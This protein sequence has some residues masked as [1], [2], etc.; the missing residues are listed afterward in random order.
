MKRSVKT[1]LRDIALV[2]LCNC[3]YAVG[4]VLFITPVS[5]ITGGTTGL[6]I[7]VHHYTQFPI[8]VFVLVFNA[9]MFLCGW[10][11]FGK[12]F[13][14]TTIVS[15]FAYPLALAFFEELFH[16][17]VLTENLML[18]ALFGGICIGVA[19]GLVIRVG[20]STGGMDIPVLMLHK[21]FRFSVSVTIYVFDVAILLLQAIFSG[22]EITLYGIVLVIVYSVVLDRVLI[23][24]QSKMQIIVI[25][26]KFEELQLRILREVDRGVTLLY[27]QTGY[28]GEETKLLLTVVSSR[29]VAKTEKIIRSIDPNA[30]MIV[31]R[32][33]EVRGRGFTSE[34][35]YLNK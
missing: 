20:S 21:F 28:L 8:S 13:A 33:S 16:G 7:F 18:C 29:E 32:V 26:R 4:V 2:F 27:G 17:V 3:L 6:A 34:K 1:L 22:A 23:V 30:F 12:K 11:T 14:L 31:N 35:N 10:L 19:I 24:G 25:R 15:T 5:L 9:A